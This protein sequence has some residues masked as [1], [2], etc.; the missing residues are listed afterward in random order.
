MGS[1]RRRA[2]AT[3]HGRLEKKRRKKTTEY[4]PRCHLHI[5]TPK[6]LG[7][8]GERGELMRTLFGEQRGSPWRRRSRGFWCGG[9]L[10]ASLS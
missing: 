8:G 10:V 1:R 2:S 3:V 7:C 9:V 5:A 6:E 4:L